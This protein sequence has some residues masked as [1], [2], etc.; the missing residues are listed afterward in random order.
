MS[1]CDYS[2]T[3]HPYS[4]QTSLSP[5]QT[6]TIRSDGCPPSK[7][8]KEEG[9]GKLEADVEIPS[10]QDSSTAARQDTRRRIEDAP[11]SCKYLYLV[12]GRASVLCDLLCRKNASLHGQGTNLS[13]SVCVAYIPRRP[14]RPSATRTLRSWRGIP[15][16]RTEKL[17]QGSAVPKS[18][19]PKIPGIPHDCL[20]PPESGWISWIQR[21]L[22][23]QSGFRASL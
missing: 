4:Q 8:N 13:P 7:R 14:L 10:C 3:S 1:I 17:P 23:W 2:C 15:D 5:T 22:E 19:P 11:L 6:C 12:F 18:V 21:I 16:W 9:A 20:R